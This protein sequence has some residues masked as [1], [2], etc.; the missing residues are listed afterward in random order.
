MNVLVVLCLPYRPPTVFPF[1]TRRL[2]A[3]SNW[4]K[5]KS[6]ASS[7]VPAQWERNALGLVE[8]EKNQNDDEE[9]EASNIANGA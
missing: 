1:I 4:K 8:K 7:S 2:D 6:L 9:K 5:G 3:I